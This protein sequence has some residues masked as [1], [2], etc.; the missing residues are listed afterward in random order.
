MINSTTLHN[1]LIP[2]MY[3]KSIASFQ[4]VPKMYPNVSKVIKKDAAFVEMSNDHAFGLIPTKNEGAAMNEL[5][6]SQGYTF[7]MNP[8]TKAAYF[9]ITQEILEDDQYD[10]CFKYSSELGKSAAETIEVDHWALW[11]GGFDTTKTE[12]GAYMFSATH[13]WHPQSGTYSNLGTTAALSVTSL[14]AAINQM[15][16]M[17]DSK[18]KKTTFMPDTLIIPIELDQKADEILKSQ[19]WPEDDSNRVNAI[20][21]FNLKV[22]VVPWLTSTTAWFLQDSRNH[23][24]YHWDRI[25]VQFGKDGDFLSTNTFYRCRFRTADG[26]Q[27]GIG[28][29]GNAGA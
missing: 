3:S 13:K 25:P 24:V 21:K 12:D 20:R 15:R 4:A 19:F 14:W 8:T 5:T 18:G 27:N 9:A 6:P 7:R 29:L 23:S 28:I 2:G 10:Q 26:V 16:K 11:N 17:T 22:L 1:L